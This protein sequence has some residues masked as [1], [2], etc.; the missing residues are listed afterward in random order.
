LAAIAGIEHAI[1]AAIAIA[2][3][4]IRVSFGIGGNVFEKRLCGA[5]VP[6]RRRLSKQSDE[7][8]LCDFRGNCNK[9]GE[10]GRRDGTTPIGTLRSILPGAESETLVTHYKN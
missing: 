7:E 2:G 3:L 8:T 5:F 10:L 4:N 6:R 1:N 9:T